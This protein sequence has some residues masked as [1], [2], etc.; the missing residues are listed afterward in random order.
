MLDLVI[1]NGTIV[2]GSGLP[3]YRG[4]VG[5]A[6]RPHRQRRA[7]PRRRRGGPGDRRRRARRRPGLHRPAHPLRRPAVLRPV[8]LP[9]HRARR[10]VGRHG[11]LLAQ[12]GARCA[13]PTASAS[14]GCSGSSRRCPRRRSTRAS[15][16]AG[17]SRS[18][19]CS[20]PSPQ[21]LAL[22]V[23]ALVGHSVLRMYVMG[24]DPR[25]AATADEVATMCD[26]LR[27]ASTPA[28]SGC[29]RAT[30]TS[31]TTCARCRAASPSTASS[32]RC[33]ACSPSGAG[34][35]RSSTSSSTPG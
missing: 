21:D 16:G 30:S 5:I 12:P 2:D 4:D 33:A 29:R 10:H 34:C 28:R 25:R 31:R 8:R 11:Q 1:R 15:T 14:R 26:V 23:G 24:D 18:A 32:R 6:R 17:V 35:C 27:E 7:P 19:G 20:T 9:G 22:N 13:R 3:R